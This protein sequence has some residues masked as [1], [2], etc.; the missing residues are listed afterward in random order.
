MRVRVCVSVS[1]VLFSVGVCVTCVD[2]LTFASPACIV[3]NTLHHCNQ[4]EYVRKK[5]EPQGWKSVG[6]AVGVNA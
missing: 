2:L 3:Y 6:R 4:Y 1:G 5:L